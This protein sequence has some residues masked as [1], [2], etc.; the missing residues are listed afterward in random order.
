[1][2]KL[3]FLLLLAISFTQVQA[4]DATTDKYV[5]QFR[6]AMVNL[7]SSWTSPVKMRETANQFER[8]ANYKKTDW[9]PFY[10]QALCL[11]Q[12]SYMGDNES[13]EATLKAAETAIKSANELSKDNSEIIA[14]EGYLYYAMILINPMANGATYSAKG[15]NTLQK[16]MSMDAN[17]PR[18][19]YLVGQN[20]YFTPAQWGGGMERARPHLE[21]AK[22]LFSQFKP[23]SEFAP[24]WGGVVCNMI[25]EGKFDK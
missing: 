17:N 20:L 25:L 7:D 13:R 2:K 21:K 23:A 6:K 9:T 14:L 19:H 1:M 4:Q 11:I 18:P 5:L 12:L 15:T 10:Y 16:A 22:A 8:L 3:L 24:N